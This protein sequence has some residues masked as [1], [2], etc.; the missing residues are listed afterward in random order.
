MT[1]ME[2]PQ[3]K[4]PGKDYR[5]SRD[6]ALHIGNT[7]NLTKF[8]NP[9]LGETPIPRVLQQESPSTARRSSLPKSIANLRKKE[10]KAPPPPNPFGDE[11]R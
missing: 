2:N 6:S 10:R 9:N 7:A 8:N 5:F 11:E 1:K 3:Y 4:G